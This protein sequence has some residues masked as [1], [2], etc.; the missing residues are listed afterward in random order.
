M[1]VEHHDRPGLGA[2]LLHTFAQLT[3]RQILQTQIDREA[4]VI[5]RTGVADHLHIL[6]Q[7][8]TAVLQNLALARHTLKP[9]VIGQLK[10]FLAL[11]VNIG[12]A[13]QMRRHL[14]GRVEPTIF[15]DAIDAVHLER[16]HRFAGGR[17]H[18]PPQIDELFV[19]IGLEALAEGRQ[20]GTQGAGKL[21]PVSLLIDQLRRVGPNGQH[22]CTDC[23]R[24][25]VAVGD[26][27]PVSRNRHMA[28]TALVA[29]TAQEAFVQHMQ[30]GNAP[31]NR[32]AAQPQQP[33]NQA[34]TPG[35]QATVGLERKSLHGFTRI[36]S[37][38]SGTCIPSCSVAIRSMRL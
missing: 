9:L 7:T 17:G 20:I 23:Q 26:L 27:P 11:L 38:G 18:A 15:F 33:D 14:T 12:E 36:T 16:H 34:K 24:L 35:V 21:R 28:H 8:T 1:H 13:D 6:D 19:G 22:R 5:A 30:L 4:Q 10:P 3:V 29:L 31:D 37:L 2:E 25:T 32:C